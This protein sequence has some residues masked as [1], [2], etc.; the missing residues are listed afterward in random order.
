MSLTLP[1]GASFYARAIDG[2]Y[3][4]NNIYLN[5]NYDVGYAEDISVVI[6]GYIVNLYIKIDEFVPG[7]YQTVQTWEYIA[8]YVTSAVYFIECVGDPANQTL[9]DSGYLTFGSYTNNN[10]EY[11]WEVSE[12]NY[13]SAGSLVGPGNYVT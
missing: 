1:I 11:Y 13:V 7:F 9:L 12:E 10:G 8:A 6:S 2:G 5:F 4:G 3:S